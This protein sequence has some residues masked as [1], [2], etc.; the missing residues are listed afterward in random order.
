MLEGCGNYCGREWNTAR[1]ILGS[2]AHHGMDREAK[3]TA[4]R[5]GCDHCTVLP[6]EPQN[7]K[8]KN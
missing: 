5:V 4:P 8:I 3:T 6:G 1:V 7:V 2:L